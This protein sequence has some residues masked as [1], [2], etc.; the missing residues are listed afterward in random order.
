MKKLLMTLVVGLLTASP[1][2]AAVFNVTGVTDLTGNITIDTVLGT[3]TAADLNYSVNSPQT[4]QT[5]LTKDSTT[6]L[7]IL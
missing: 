3:V 7:P 2:Y 4:I 1:S 5:S 6:L